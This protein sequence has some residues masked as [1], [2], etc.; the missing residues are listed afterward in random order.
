MFQTE[1]GSSSSASEA[2][3]LKLTK[4]SPSQP[5]REKVR[6]L[7]YGS[8]RAVDR[9]IDQLQVLGF[10]EQFLWTPIAPIPENDIRITRADGEAYA[11]LIRELL[12]D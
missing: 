7:I 2:A 9:T 3:Q 4:T 1:Y 12:I 8:R 10:A 5:E 6:L 11:F